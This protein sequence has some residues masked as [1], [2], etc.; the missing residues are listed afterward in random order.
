MWDVDIL[1]SFDELIID[2]Y[3]IVCL[4]I[5]KKLIIRL[6]EIDKMQK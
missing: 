6:I 4:L 5:Y 1:W 3:L 2:F